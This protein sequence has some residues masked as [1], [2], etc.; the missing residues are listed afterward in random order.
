MNYRGLRMKQGNVLIPRTAP[1]IL[2]DIT[3]KST[4]CGQRPLALEVAQLLPLS[5]G[6]LPL[7]MAPLALRRETDYVRVRWRP[8]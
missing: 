6:A 5:P 8:T 4:T 1:V 2:R 7:I 3:D